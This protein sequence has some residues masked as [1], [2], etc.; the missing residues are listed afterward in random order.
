[1]PLPPISR[2]VAQRGKSTEGLG[3][4]VGGTL[5]RLEADGSSL[6]NPGPAAGAAVLFY[7]DGR[8]LAEVAQPIGIATSNVA[9]YT[10]LII[11][12]RRA[13]LE[14]VAD[15]L[16]QMDSRLVIN[17]VRR[18]WK[19][20]AHHL[21][22]FA[23][24]CWQLL[25]LFRDTHLVWVPREQNALADSLATDAATK[26]ASYNAGLDDAEVPGEAFLPAG[27]FP[28]ADAP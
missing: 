12:L 6:G 10:A 3:F 23:E 17:Q 25:S 15:L 20:R 18:A 11:G 27:S 4:G 24:C 26:Q 2:V 13:V 28:A 19:I 5:Y 1:M 7:P 8:L 16:V 14:G 9:E 22:P 21:Q